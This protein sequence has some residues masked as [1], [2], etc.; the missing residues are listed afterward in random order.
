LL[1]E[2]IKRYKKKG[3]IPF[4]Y[5]ETRIPLDNATRWNSTYNIIFT[6]LELKEALSYIN[7]ITKNTNFKRYFLTNNE[8][9]ELNELKRI[10]EIFIKQSTKLQ[11]ELSITLNI[12]LLYIY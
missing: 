5:N 11:S 7:K 9:K 3:L 1:L 8:F 12:T 2:G 4:N 10:F 6:T